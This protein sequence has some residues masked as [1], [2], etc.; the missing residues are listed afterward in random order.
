MHRILLQENLFHRKNLHGVF[1]D[2]YYKF[3]ESKK[4]N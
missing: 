4:M 1:Q 2:K 3:N